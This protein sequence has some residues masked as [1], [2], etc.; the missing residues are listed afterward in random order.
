MSAPRFCD[1]QGNP[2]YGVFCAVSIE[3]GEF[4]QAQENRVL[5]IASS[6]ARIS[7]TQ[8]QS[9]HRLAIDG[10]AIGVVTMVSTFVSRTV[11]YNY[12][13]ARAI[14]DGLPPVKSAAA[15]PNSIRRASGT[16]ADG[17]AA[18]TDP[19]GLAAELCAGRLSSHMGFDPRIEKE[20]CSA[21]FDPCPSVDFN[22]AGFM[23]FA[24]LIAMI[25]R[26][27]Y[28]LDREAAPRATTAARDVFFYGNVVRNET[29]EVRLLGWRREPDQIVHHF[30]MIRGS[31]GRA[32]A[33]VFTKRVL[34]LPGSGALA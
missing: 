33:D 34:G 31:D 3:E 11:G 32:T 30:R 12:A 23:Y 21:A 24:N 14:A 26:M 9:I 1:R 28:R 13:I 25:D 20:V 4:R 7:H 29:V 19:A 17:A 6:L 15:D 27:E 16:S 18:L 5:Q 22:S 10:F 2:V 8:V